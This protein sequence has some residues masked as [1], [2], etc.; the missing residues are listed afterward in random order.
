MKNNEP[1][2]TVPPANSA[3]LADKILILLRDDTGRERMGKTGAEL[4][5]PYTMANYEKT[6][7][8]IIEDFYYADR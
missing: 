1:G 3:E 7:E 6:F 8:K 4:V 2:F 5:K